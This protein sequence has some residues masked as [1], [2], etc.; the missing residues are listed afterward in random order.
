[1]TDQTIRDYGALVDR[2]VALARQVVA[3]QRALI[4]SLRRQGQSTIYAET[5]LA[6]YEAVSTLHIPRDEQVRN[7]FDTLNLMTC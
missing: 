7:A 1:M 3:S 6:R 4:E 2:R 5:A